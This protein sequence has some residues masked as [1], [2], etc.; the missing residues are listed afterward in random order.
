M[1]RPS[2]RAAAL[3]LSR[4]W[5]SPTGRD[6]QTDAMADAA[7]VVNPAGR[8]H[9]AEFERVIAA[10]SDH[11]QALARAVRALVYD[12][13]PGTVEVVWAQQGSVGWGVGP[14]KYT[15]QFAYLMPFKNHVTLG[16]YRG[17]E[18]PDL[19]GLLPTT[20]GRQVGGKLSMRSLK[21]TTLDD[22]NRPAL[23]ALIDA[24][25]RTGI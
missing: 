17:G 1:E 2:L 3:A 24:S 4:S 23:R 21:L 20:G 14:K 22:I 25:T 16:F 9:D 10:S 19:E 6:R 18:L 13:L 12:V 8:E 5:L 15:E 7:G 11:V